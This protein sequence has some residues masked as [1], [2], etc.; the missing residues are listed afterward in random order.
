MKN[1][2]FG[3]RVDTNSF[4]SA[5]VPQLNRKP[6]TSSGSGIWGRIKWLLQLN[7]NAGSTIL[8]TS[9]SAVLVISV[10]C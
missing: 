4:C 3:H 6:E 10:V 5:I 2:E 7:G 9:L 1:V 8:Y